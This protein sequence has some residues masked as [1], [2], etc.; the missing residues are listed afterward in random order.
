M[1]SLI[2]EIAAITAESSSAFIL[3][4]NKI[5]KLLTNSLFRAFFVNHDLILLNMQ[6]LYFLLILKK[7]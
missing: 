6:N 1:V 2:F 4:S 5:S 3:S 7:V